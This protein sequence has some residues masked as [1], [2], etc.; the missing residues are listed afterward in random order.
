[1]S[2]LSK[3]QQYLENQPQRPSA[4]TVKNYVSDIRHFIKWYETSFHKDFYAEDLTPEVVE[5]YTKSYGSTVS[6]EGYEIIDSALASKSLKRHLSALRKFSVFLLS[7]DIIPAA[8]IEVEKPEP[9]EDIWQ[10]EAFKRHLAENNAADL[11]I[12][13]YVNDVIGFT[14]WAH[15]ISR[16][17]SSLP[18]QTQL[19]NYVSYQD[20]PI[21]KSYLQQ[22]G[23]SDSSINRK[24]S[25][26][27]K[28][29]T[30][31]GK[32]LEEAP[33][34]PSYEISSLL[35]EDLV[36][37]N[38]ELPIRR[39]SSFLPFKLAQK[40]ADSYSNLEEKTAGLFAKETGH[41]NL[42]AGIPKLENR[43][44]KERLN[45]SSNFKHPN[46]AS[47]I[48]SPA[49]N[50][51][52]SGLTAYS[53]KTP[54]SPDTTFGKIL[55]TFRHKRPAWYHAYHSYSVTH[56]F[57][58][59]LV[60]LCGAIA[61]IAAYQTYYGPTNKQTYAAE[62]NRLIPFT[63]RIQSA[64]G[65]SIPEVQ[66]I[67]FAIYNDSQ[68]SNHALL[69]K[70]TQTSVK[71]RPDGTFT[72]LVGSSTEIPEKLFQENENMFLGIQIGSGPEL[73]PRKQLASMGYSL[74]SATLG[75][76]L[77][78]TDS[79]EPS[80]NAVVALDSAGD[81]VLPG[82]AS[83][84]FKAAAGDLTISGETLTLTTNTGSNTNVIISP[85]GD[86]KIDLTKGL[87]NTT[88]NGVISPGAVEVQDSFAVNAGNEFEP[89]LLVNSNGT[90]DLLVASSS[91]SVKFVV[92]NNGNVG[93]GTDSP[94]L[95]LTVS[96]GASISDRLGIG[97]LLPAA[98]LDVRGESAIF[99]GTKDFTLNIAKGSASS[100]AQLKFHDDTGSRATIGLI[101]NNKLSF[102]VT[103]NAGQVR[104]G[105]VIDNATGNIGVGTT[106]IYDRLTIAGN[107]SPDEDNKYNLGS[108]SRRFNKIYVNEIIGPSIGTQGFWQ[109][110]GTSIAPTTVTDSM[111][112]GSAVESTALIKLSGISGTNSW[113]NSGNLGIGTI[114]PSFRLD[115]TDTSDTNGIARFTN[116]SP[117]SQADLLVLKVGANTPGTDNRYI[118]FVDGNNNPIGKVTGNGSGGVTYSTTG[119]DFAEY[120]KKENP[121]EEMD[122][123]DLVCLG[124]SGGITRCTTTQTRLV[125]VI[126]NQAGFVGNSKFDGNSTY[127][128]VGLLGQI[129]VKTVDQDLQEGDALTI[130]E[131]PGK[132][133]KATTAGMI[134]GR[135]ISK[136]AHAGD[137]PGRAPGSAESECNEASTDGREGSAGPAGI[138]TYICNQTVQIS[139][140]PTWYDPEVFLSSAGDIS[141]S[142][143]SNQSTVYDGSLE[144]QK[145]KVK[146][147]NYNAK[148]GNETVTKVGSFFE[149]ASAKIKS[150]L[151]QTENAIVNNTLVAKNVVVET[152]TIDGQSLDQYIANQV[153][154]SY[155]VIRPSNIVSPLASINQIQTNTI[156]PLDGNG[157]SIDVGTSQNGSTNSGKLNITSDQNTVA[158]IDS[159]GNV[160]AE[161]SISARSA[162][163]SGQLAAE[164]VA[165]EQLTVNQNATISGKLTVNEIDAKSIN[166]LNQQIATLMQENLKAIRSGDR[167]T[168]SSDPSDFSDSPISDSPTIPNLK[169]E[170][171]V[172]QQG[173]VSFG[174]ATFNNASVMDSFSIGTDWTFQ[175]HA[176]NVIGNDLEIQTL[177]QGGVSFLA[178]LVTINKEGNMTVEGDLKVNGTLFANNSELDKLKAGILSPL[179]DNDLV[180]Q[181]GENQTA[182]RSSNLSVQ[183]ASGSAVLGINDRGD[184][185]SSGSA[186]VSKL[187]LKLAGQAYA[188][189][190]T[191]SIATG[192]AGTARI[193][194]NRPEMTIYTPEVTEESLIYITPVGNTSQ[195]IYL[196]RQTAR[197]SFTVGISK[198]SSLDV[199][200]NW[201]IIN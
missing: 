43:G 8:I 191:E 194:A 84:T 166:G 92:T 28:Y 23:L 87:I 158:S 177:R 111:L 105:L 146:S 137:D 99:S 132:A 197:E 121:G 49:S 201:I 199:P 133:K 119:A 141:V 160:Y 115:V 108:E 192:S 50:P 41:S 19:L 82:D 81:I 171:A 169:A 178:G 138:S 195:P 15:E 187:N 2:I 176:I 34:T 200:F 136:P 86:G 63:G 72:T 117:T 51:P 48:E 88:D 38:S 161:G 18:S 45:P 78:I 122:V 36:N 70:E 156:S 185:N 186:T 76:M 31:L 159:E 79:S 7:E 65:E 189:S 57:H 58:M 73:K 80:Y 145:S 162:T 184:L 90:G 71:I 97:T 190:D 102:Q 165:S 89:A 188:V 120:F 17:D 153:R 56:Y 107:I 30:F 13:N 66:D 142:S 55:H 10:I 175:N 126:S 93:I 33:Q 3:F 16:M 6:P 4:V 22:N 21:Y 149:I 44:L 106:N 140:N 103:D 11:T 172:I 9:V 173:L 64:R 127:A 154:D 77:P 123:G 47:S 5:L 139:L 1:M 12:K 96:G 198:L 27:K 95:P 67:T 130:S 24:M 75:N 39:Y 118:T 114:N 163:F 144:S 182:T 128:L 110:N 85:D 32:P 69:W 174:P 196:L 152:L 83:H 40:T 183:N 60:I 135:I 37:D 131:V 147:Q 193:R 157:I 150:G 179:S 62:S 46:Q 61:S 14:K 168:D 20:F 151:V 113:I 74:D 26:I 91:G 181:L 143:D 148:V 129:P 94:N 116:S 112:L 29:F 68:D 109:R 100:S 59:A 124:S 35:L 42:E 52:S 54:P 53:K 167:R 98:N 125:G 25:S 104:N 101:T 164:S 155:S 134:I 170:F 180:V